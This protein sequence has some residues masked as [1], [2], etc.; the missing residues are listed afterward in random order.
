MARAKLSPELKSAISD[1]TEKEKDK[2][3]FR[4]LP[5]D[6]K[7]VHKLEYQLLEYAD[8]QEDRRSDVRALIMEAMERYPSYYYSPGY[9]L[10]TLRE[11]SGKITYHK[12]ITSDKVGEIELNYLM[13]TEGLERNIS[14]LRRSG[15][16]SMKSLNEYVV[17]RVLKLLKLTAKL[18]EDYI[19]EFEESMIK[20]GE[21]LSEI[22]SM[23]NYIREHDLDLHSLIEGR[24]P[25]DLL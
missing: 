8:T 24:L 19:L 25:D 15:Y 16:F 9:L 18:H 4:L 14:S 10:L 2:L 11:L 20:M 5:K 22:P 17:K 7:L 3:I 13:L 23:S 6:Q 1:L 12:D 21:L